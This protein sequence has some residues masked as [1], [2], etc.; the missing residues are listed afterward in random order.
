MN[1][2]GYVLPGMGC[3][4]WAAA[5]INAVIMGATTL[6]L[7][8]IGKRVPCPEHHANVSLPCEMWR[9][10]P[11]DRVDQASGKKSGLKSQRKGDHRRQYTT[12]S[13]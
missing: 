8:S 6:A 4:R 12:H 2:I 3:S 10:E 7:R 5:K 13:G 1:W 11:G 9:S